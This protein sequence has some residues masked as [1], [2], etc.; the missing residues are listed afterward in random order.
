VGI[1]DTFNIDSGIASKCNIIVLRTQ[2]LDCIIFLCEALLYLKAFAY[3]C[4]FLVIFFSCL[5]TWNFAIKGKELPVSFFH[6][7]SIPFFNALSG[8][9]LLCL[10]RRRLFIFRT[11]FTFL[12]DFCF[13]GA[14]SVRSFVVVPFFML[15]NQNELL[16]VCLLW[17]T[18]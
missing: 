17:L 15:I 13:L 2:H 11:L 3:F 7:L 16:F 12:S 8:N 1:Q 4:N 5:R 10:L 6:S 9:S 14:T 18:S